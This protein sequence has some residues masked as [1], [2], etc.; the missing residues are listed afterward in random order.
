MEPMRPFRWNVARGDRLGSLLDGHDHEP[1]YLPH[2][3]ECA[4]KVLARSS[5]GDLYFVG[6][7]AD[8]VFDLLSGALA[9]TR[10][11]SRLHQLPL[12]L[13]GS[14][15]ADLTATERAQLRTN[16][17]SSGLS[18]N[19][20]AGRRRPVVFADL[21]LA[22]STFT[23]LHHH[24][25]DWIDDE[26]ASWNVIRTKIRYVGITV[27]E[28]TSP[29]TWRWQQHEDWVTELPGKAVCNVSVD[30]WLWRYLGNDQ[31]KTAHS[32]R[33]TRWSDPEVT[34]PRHDEK[35]RR[36]LAIAVALYQSG[37][38]RE[39]R[40]EIHRVLTGE[41]TFRE[42]WLRDIARALRRR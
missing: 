13:Y 31:P 41:P 7:S 42:P 18:P 15:G 4:A 8:S 34:V 10:F 17:T 35:A 40:E 2:L 20:L 28:K 1:A 38:T 9:D 33:R 11:A 16:L 29:N 24:L 27:R 37:R 22:G 26:R 19:G 25:R 23:N 32:F 5:D 3:V 39:V 30:L 6:R 21:V 36:G 12:S 14:D